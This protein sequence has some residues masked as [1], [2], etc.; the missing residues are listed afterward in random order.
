MTERHGLVCFRQGQAEF[1]QL[2]KNFPL[3][4]RSLIPAYL[5]IQG[6]ARSLSGYAV[7]YGS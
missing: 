5:N 1:A 7:S 3:V 6:L 2:R 4:H